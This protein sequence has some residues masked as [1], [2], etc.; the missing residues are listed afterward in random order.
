MLQHSPDVDGCFGDVL[1]ASWTAPVGAQALLLGGHEVLQVL[2]EVL[3]LIPEQVNL[4][5]SLV[6]L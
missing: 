5:C 6:D 1:E 3:V 4:Q 2:R